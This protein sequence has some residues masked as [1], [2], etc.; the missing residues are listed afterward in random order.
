[1]RHDST[2]EIAAAVRDA[3]APLREEIARLKG[4]VNFLTGP[5][6][7]AWAS[8][9]P[10][11]LPGSEQLT[12]LPTKVLRARDAI[13]MELRAEID[14]RG[15]SAAIWAKLCAEQALAYAVAIAERDTTITELRAEIERLD[16]ENVLA[17]Q[18][19]DEYRRA[20][21]A[22]NRT[23]IERDDHLSQAHASLAEMT[24]CRTAADVQHVIERNRGETWQRFSRSDLIA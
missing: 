12:V 3:T 11:E 7:E 2:R 16:R 14:K 21:D 18:A 4:R 20:H 10:V 19:R 24:R 13:I 15:R 23:I 6:Y 17:L 1:M 22:A 8:G 9:E 5:N